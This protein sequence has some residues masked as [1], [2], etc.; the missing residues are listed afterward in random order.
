MSLD[1]F[2][3]LAPA[4]QKLQVYVK[5]NNFVEMY[6]M[7]LFV[8][9]GPGRGKTI[10]SC[11]FVCCLLLESTAAETATRFFVIH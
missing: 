1:K 10:A 2:W 7:E 3:D 5:V 8:V 9:H 11:R 6:H 4:P